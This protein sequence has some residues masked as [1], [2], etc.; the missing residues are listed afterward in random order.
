MAEL[1]PY[2]GHGVFLPYLINRTATFINAS[3][4]RRVLEPSGLTLTHWRVLAFL[5]T[6]EGLTMG[7]LA[8][9]T[10]TEQSTL[11]RSLRTLEVRGYVHRRPCD[12]DSR[13]V[14]VQ[15]TP[16]GRAQF[17]RMLE[18]VLELEAELLQGVA[19]DET[20]AVRSVL[21][22]VIANCPVEPR[23]S[24]R[25]HDTTSTQASKASSALSKVSHSASVPMEMRRN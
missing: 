11:S 16:E 18:G 15:L 19:A 21:L 12:A 22:R 5:T 9:A 14:Q 17:E 24:R 23:G 10:M 6:V 4:Q 3:L 25:S 2:P 7:A 20:E 8:D 13:A 1:P